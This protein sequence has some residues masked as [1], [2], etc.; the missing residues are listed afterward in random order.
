MGWFDEQ[1][2]DRK[3]NDDD[4]FAEAFANMASAVMGKRIEAAINDNRAA[5]KDAID[6]I[7]KYYH[8]KSR[9]VPDN[10]T[11][12]NEQLEYLM[13]PNGIMRRTVKLDKG[14]AQSALCSESLK[15]A[16]EWSLLSR[17]DCRGTP[18]L[19]TKRENANV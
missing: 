16:A 10:I 19:T 9:E 12:M 7:L 2:R 6:E 4:A 8:V 1:I 11:D 17:R 13:R 5:T 14:W 3:Q 15:R 18:I